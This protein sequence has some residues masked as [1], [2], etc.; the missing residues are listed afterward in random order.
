LKVIKAIIIFSCPVRDN[1]AHSYRHQGRR[2]RSWPIC[3]HTVRLGLL[4]HADILPRHHPYVVHLKRMCCP[5]ICCPAGSRDTSIFPSG[6]MH[7]GWNPGGSKI[8]Q[9]SS[10]L[11]DDA[12]ASSSEDRSTTAGRRGVTCM[13]RA[14]ANS[15]QIGV[16][17]V[18]YSSKPFV[19]TWGGGFLTRQAPFV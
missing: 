15:L 2:A 16:A 11:S 9:N 7:T 10:L 14:Y 3:L 8:D 5:I 12:A 18:I 1:V 13:R 17:S 19:S 4:F 6:G